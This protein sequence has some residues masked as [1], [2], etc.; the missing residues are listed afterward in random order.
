MEFLDVNINVAFTL[1]NARQIEKLTPM[2]A[3]NNWRPCE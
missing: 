3:Q 1:T 2:S